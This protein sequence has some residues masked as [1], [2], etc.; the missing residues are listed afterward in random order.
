MQ[1]RHRAC[2]AA[3]ERRLRK[4]VQPGTRDREQSPPPELVRKAVGSAEGL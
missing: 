2:V 4:C 1:R 3:S